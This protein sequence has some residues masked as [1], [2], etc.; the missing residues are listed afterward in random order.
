M[1][2]NLRAYNIWLHLLHFIIISF[3]AQDFNVFES[4]IQYYGMQTQ[5]FD[6]Y[7]HCEYYHLKLSLRDNRHI[8]R[9]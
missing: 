1:N 8:L 6:K 3:V 7:Y 2:N 4:S 5:M 9:V